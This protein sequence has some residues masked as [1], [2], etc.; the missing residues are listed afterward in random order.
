MVGPRH[1]SGLNGMNVLIVEVQQEIS[2]F[3]P[4][5]TYKMDETILH[6]H[7]LSRQSYGASMLG[8]NFDQIK[9]TEII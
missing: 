7:L 9:V 2:N 5:D 6:Y 1:F 8:D 4:E 3:D